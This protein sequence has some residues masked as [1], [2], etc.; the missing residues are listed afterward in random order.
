VLTKV[1]FTEWASSYADAIRPTLGDEIADQIIAKAKGRLAEIEDELYEEFTSRIQQEISSLQ[2]EVFAD[3]NQRLEQ[4][5][6]I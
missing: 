4:K 6:I 3:V 1:S 5:G 2:L